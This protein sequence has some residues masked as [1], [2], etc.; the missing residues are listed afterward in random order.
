ML[1]GPGNAIMTVVC[2]I[3]SGLAAGLTQ[4]L[5]SIDSLELKV[6]MRSGTEEE[7]FHA[8]R[9]LSIVQNHHLLLV[10]LLLFNAA[11]NEALPLFLDAMVPSW[12]ALIL[13]VTLVMLCGDIIPS[14]IF[15]GPNQLRIASFLAPFVRIILVLFW[16]V[17]YPISVLLDA[18][19]GAED[20]VTLLNRKEISALIRIQQEEGKKQGLS[21]KNIVHDSEIAIIEQALSLRD[22]TVSAVMMTSLFSLSMD[23]RLDVKV[24]HFYFV[25]H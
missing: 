7:K 9:V 19:V 14:A 21:A 18:I 4:G 1:P 23:D 6:K 12:V 10:S 15:T 20:P 24:R 13:S 8:S 2:I 5:L 11:A 3:G 16:P 17:S 22:L 25:F